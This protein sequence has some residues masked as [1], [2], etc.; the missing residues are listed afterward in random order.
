[1]KVI[2]D[3]ENCESQGVCVRNCP[4]VFELDDDD[5]LQILIEDIPENLMAHVRRCVERCPKQALSLE[6]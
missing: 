2:V 5:R 1:M 6:E 4:Q 3:R